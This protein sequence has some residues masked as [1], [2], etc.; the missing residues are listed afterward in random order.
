M[1]AI[2]PAHRHPRHDPLRT[3]RALT[4][5]RHEPAGPPVILFKVEAKRGDY[6]P[7][8]RLCKREVSC[9]RSGYPLGCPAD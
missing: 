5:G 1:R 2:E 4:Q 3:R 8:V 6:R 9:G 7:V